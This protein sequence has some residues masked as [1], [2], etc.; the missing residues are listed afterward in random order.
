MQ[1]RIF[2]HRDA[3]WIFTGALFLFTVV[4]MPEFQGMNARFA[5]F[6]QEMMRNGPSCF[7]TTYGVP[8]PD[9][10]ATSTFLIYLLSVPLGKVTP[11][12]AVLPSAIASALVLVVIYRIG[13]LHSRKWGVW[14]VFFALSTKSFFS[15]SRDISPDQYVSL[16]TVFSFYLVY[17]ARVRGKREN[18][19]SLFPLLLAGFLFRGPLGLVI[20][21]GVLCGFY[22]L[23][24]DFSRL[25]LFGGGALALLTLA[26]GVLLAAASS[27]GGETFVK[28][29]IRMEAAGRITAASHGPGYYWGKGLVKYLPA[30]PLAL[31]VFM[32]FGRGL[33]R[34][35][36]EE[37]RLIRHSA[38]WIVIILGGLSIPGVKKMR[39][40]LPA[41]PPFALAAAWLFAGSTAN[42]FLGKARSLL[43]GLFRVVPIGA[44][45]FSLSVLLF[46]KQ[47]GFDFVRHGKIAFA[48]F[49]MLVAV[50]EIG[51]P[52][53]KKISGR[54]AAR[55]AVTTVTLI[56]LTLCYSSPAYYARLESG[57][58]IRAVSRELVRTKADLAFYRIPKDGL[59]VTF[60][61][62]L[63]RPIYP[64][65][66]S[67]PDQL[68]GTGRDD[69]IIIKEEDFS[70]LPEGLRRDFSILV[71]GRLEKRQCLLIRRKDPDWTG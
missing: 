36:G 66:L 26:S 25:L 69:R 50:G 51:I 28:Q 56:L 21:A 12:S 11:L 47:W 64:R 54:E 49:V 70:R 65:F 57:P 18:L 30:Y 16:V 38:L 58:F 2:L 71:R 67:T 6:A 27:E 31:I 14:S 24:R 37:M 55:M 29:V 52:R 59:A 61:A 3:F 8:Y 5:L 10:P 9:Y 39:Y 17:S 19:S 34:G 40:I 7:P 53:L 4:L 22:L 48:I 46:R 45:L 63:G 68:A 42:R 1:D 23:E 20:P 15:Y 62:N 32:G 13:A 33:F 43:L 35:S 41:V 44:L 60:M